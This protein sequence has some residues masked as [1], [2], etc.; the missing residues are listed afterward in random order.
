MTLNP[1]YEMLANRVALF[2]GISPDDIHKI[3]SRGLTMAMEKGNIIFY[4]GTTGNQMFVILAGRVS[5][6]DG[7]KHL[8]DLRTGDMFGE[9]ALINNEPRS[10]T[11][12]AAEQTQLFI[13]SETFFQRL[14]TKKVAIQML[15]NIIGTLSTRLQ[16][17][18]KRILEMKEESARS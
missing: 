12:V 9:M 4:K 17:M 14:M 1:K 3:I 6:F 8:A 2:K 11:A 5:L 15:L 7:Q 18:N 13:M 16:S 10:A